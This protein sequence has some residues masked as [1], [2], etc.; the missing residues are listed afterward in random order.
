MGT[1][2]R[3]YR[4]IFG[5][6]GMSNPKGDSYIRQIEDENRRLRAELEK[7][8]ILNDIARAISSAWSLE[9]I[10]ELVVRQCIKH[11]GAEQGSITLLDLENREKPFHTMIRRGDRT[12]GILPFRLD[13]QLRGWMLQYQQPLLVND[14]LS[15]SRFTVDPKKDQPIQSVLSVPLRYKGRMIGSLNVFNK[16]AAEGFTDADQQVLTIIGTDVAQVIENARLYEEEQALRGMRKEMKLAYEIQTG[17]LPQGAPEIPGYDIS[18]RSIPAQDV[19]GDYYDFIH[20][21]G[22]RVGVCLGDVSGKGVPA[23]L[24]MANVQATLRGQTIQGLSPKECLEQSNANLMGSMD[25]GRFITLFYAVLD[26]ENHELIYANAG[27]N[28]P[29]L[30]KAGKEATRL[31]VSG[32]AL[33]SI[34]NA[35]YAEG[36]MAMAP[37]DIFVVFSDGITEAIDMDEDLF[38]EQRLSQIVSQNSGDTAEHLIELIFSAVRLHAGES[39]QSDDMTAVVIKRERL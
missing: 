29:F 16:R 39:S 31:E 13:A 17:L 33:G 37:G 7:L 5:E 18:G 24:L 32:I 27:H 26:S 38:G 14:L 11:L 9:Q 35:R 23:A 2:Q 19:G 21:G 4:L 1:S 3:V 20:M 28:H 12:E 36:R 30:F 22:H 10:M 15:D 34:D 25:A 6:S 8:T